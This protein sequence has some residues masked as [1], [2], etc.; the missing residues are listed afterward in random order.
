MIDL[1]TQLSDIHRSV[2]READATSGDVVRVT[3]TR[4]Y[5]TTP[6]DLWSALTD[7]ARIARW[8]MPVTGELTEG[9]HFDLEGNASGEVIECDAPR[10]F[11]VTFG[12]P[13]SIVQVTLAAVGADATE[14]TLDH[15]VPI[16]MAQNIAGALFVGP[17]WDGA[18]L[19]IR[20]HLDGFVGDPKE[21]ANS[22]EVIAA[23]VASLELWRA[24]VEAAG[25]TADEVATMYGIAH[26]QYSGVSEPPA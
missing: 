14:L 15:A 4:R 7:P 17:G 24:V 8:F 18:L 13:E 3:L 11:R 9:G 16:A 26:A 22:P 20:M 2:A 25:A 23:N 6:D 5:A 21:A 19:G 10:R 12:G 1:L